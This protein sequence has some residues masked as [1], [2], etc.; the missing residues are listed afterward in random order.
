MKKVVIG[1]SV[2]RKEIEAALGERSDF[3]FNWLED[4][5]HNVPETLHEKVQAAIDAET[6]AER[7]YLLYGHCG[8][9]LTGIQAKNCPVVLPKVE[10]CIDVLLCHNPNTTEMR[11]SSYFVSQGWLWGEEGLGYEYDRMKEKYGEKRA[12]R[13]IKAMYK[14]YKY[15]M[16]VKT[17]VEN[18]SV[19]EKCAGV[20]EKLNLELQETEGDV[21]LIIEM[22]GGST[23]ERFIVIPPGEMIRE[24]MFRAG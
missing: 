11:R 22:L 8:Q 12:L 20:A 9:A 6:G 7:I 21:D 19:R 2:L 24:E 3:K 1:C 15:L 4:Q 18:Q 16:F 23:D 14:N 10:D 13:V 5:L 17:G